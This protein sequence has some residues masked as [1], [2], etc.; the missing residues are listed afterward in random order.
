[1][2]GG[3]EIEYDPMS[4]SCDLHDLIVAIGVSAENVPELIKRVEVV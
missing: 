3:D 1:M 4:N 2:R